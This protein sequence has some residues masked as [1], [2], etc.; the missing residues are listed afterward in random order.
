[1]NKSEF[2]EVGPYLEQFAD[3]PMI[4]FDEEVGLAKKIELGK[5]GAIK[6]SMNCGAGLELFLEHFNNFLDNYKGK[7]DNKVRQIRSNVVT[8]SRI[9]EQKIRPLDCMMYDHSEL[10][11]L[12]EKKKGYVRRAGVLLGECTESMPFET[13]IKLIK[14][15]ECSYESAIS[16]SVGYIKKFK[17]TNSQEKA[18]L[19]QRMLGILIKYGQ[20]LQAKHG[21]LCKRM[22]AWT[23]ARDRLAEANLGLVPKIAKK[24]SDR[25]LGYADLI[26]EGNI[27]LMKAV[28]RFEWRKG[29]KFATYAG[30]WIKQAIERALL[31]KSLIHIPSNVHYNIPWYVDYVQNFVR[32]S[33]RE[34]TAE[35]TAKEL[36]ITLGYVKCLKQAALIAK[37]KLMVHKPSI[38]ELA[39]SGPYPDEAAAC[40]VFKEE[41]NEMV[42]ELT[43]RT[44]KIIMQRYG[45]DGKD[46]MTLEQ[47][48]KTVG[49]TRERVR[50]I[51]AKT[52]KQILSD[53]RKARI[54]EKNVS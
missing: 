31:Q 9:M 2:D 21:V 32:N 7:E 22:N 44:Q 46:P 19:G 48:G 45:L 39:G 18:R 51:E 38:E 34:P 10:S 5:K 8:A 36:N 47:I 53:P 29:C 13:L 40:N 16:D 43:P 35:E 11:D 17:S 26:C 1:M 24:Y 15:V 42:A 27:G 50:Q 3:Y 23:S 14:K 37:P 12:L 54:L 20:N 49:V 6:A 52:L 4:G 33:A 41:L 30:W 28:D 25:G